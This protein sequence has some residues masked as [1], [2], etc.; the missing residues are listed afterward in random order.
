[1]ATDM[2]PHFC[3]DGELVKK[4]IEWCKEHGLWK[5]NPNNTTEEKMNLY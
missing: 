2:A 4:H 1:M 5:T 3:N